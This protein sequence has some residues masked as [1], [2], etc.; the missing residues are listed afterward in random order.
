MPQAKQALDK[1]R[2]ET[3]EWS[4]LEDRRARAEE[5]LKE[6]TLTRHVVDVFVEKVIVYQDGKTEIRWK[7]EKML[8]AVSMV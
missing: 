2:K 6:R 7:Q 5:M 8:D 3:T 1:F 4:R